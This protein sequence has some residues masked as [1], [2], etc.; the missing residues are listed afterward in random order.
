MTNAVTGSS[1]STHRISVVV[2]VYQGEKTLPEV[3]AEL[4]GLAEPQI[5]PAGHRFVIAEVLLVF[6]HGPDRSAQVIRDLAARYDIVRGVWLSR[7][8]GQHPATLAGMASAGGDWVVT[9]D[10]DGQH[11]PAAI[12]D[13]LDTA[14][15]RQSTLVYALPSNKPPH[16]F[17]RNAASKSA[18]KVVAALLSSN[19]APNYQSFRLVTGEV[20][21]SVAAYAGNAVYL[22]VA[23]GWIASNV[24][25]CPVALRE[26]GDRASGYRLRTLLSHFWRMVISSGTRGLRLVS[27]IGALFAFLGVCLAIYL[28]IAY[29][30]GHG[31]GQQGWTSTMIVILI[32]TGAILFSLGVIAEYVGVNVNMAMGKPAYLIVSDPAVGPLGKASTV[33]APA[34]QGTAA[35]SGGNTPNA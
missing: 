23:L 2:P 32:S 8:F 12:G 18:K 21:R 6:D 27:L 33:E 29:L 15:A 20:A 11:D 7:N 17:L 30:T 35:A 5:S 19:D 26:E 24:A 14:M 22:D 10:E 1:A 25:T 13:M 4:M 9:M 16:G 34:G 3:V 31:A 28:L